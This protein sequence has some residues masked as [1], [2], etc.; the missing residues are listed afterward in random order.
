MRNLF[1]CNIVILTLV[2]MLSSCSKEFYQV[3]TAE[4]KS[5]ET[6][7]TGM[8]YEDENC[9]IT[10]NLWAPH[11]N[12]GFIFYNKTDKNII[13]DLKE[14]FFVFNGYAN[15]YYLNRSYVYGKSANIGIGKSLGK[16]A[17]Y[18]ETLSGTLYGNWFGYN[19]SASGSMSGSIGASQNNTT[20]VQAGANA[21]VEIKEQDLIC[22]PPK[23]SKLFYEYQILENIY[24]ECGFLLSPKKSAIKRL[25]YADTNSPIKFSNVISYCISE[26][27]NP[28][29]V[30]ND[31][32]ISS[33]TNI[34]AGEFITEIRVEKDCMGK[35][36][37]ANGYK[38]VYKEQAPNKFYIRYVQN[39][40][41][42]DKY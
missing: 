13:I 41:N 22:I 26:Q 2:I 37:G 28:I 27:G 25:K 35:S 12:A 39:A 23:T 1:C 17:S 4:S 8:V 21:S 38:T 15:D 40:R 3:L 32:Y 31:F 11:G 33:I 42:S 24:R 6:Q 14:C 5:V 19:A 36:Y 18:S 7:Q 20:F 10:Y 9:K 16:S 29:V 34:S 30:N